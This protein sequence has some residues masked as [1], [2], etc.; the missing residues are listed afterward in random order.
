MADFQPAR[1]PDEELITAAFSSY[2]A[3]APKNFPHPPAAEVMAKA[4]T[5]RPRKRA[6]T[7]SLAALAFTGL[8][9]G[10]AA[11]AQTVASSG[12]M[13]DD[14]GDGSSSVASGEDGGSSSKDPSSSSKPDDDKT[15]D[16]DLHGLAITLP[17]WP[18]AAADCPAGTYTFSK[19]GVSKPDSKW[20]LASDG[21]VTALDDDGVSN[22]LIVEIDCDELSGVI[23]LER[24]DDEATA[25]DFVDTAEPGTAID[26]VSVDGNKVTVDT[27]PST[28]GQ[29]QET[30]V[31]D[32]DGFNE[33]PDEEPSDEPSSSSGTPSEEPSTSSPGSESTSGLLDPG[34]RVANGS[35]EPSVA[36][37]TP[38]DPPY[39][40][41]R[42]RG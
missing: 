12:E 15:E 21:T 8:I 40:D 20:S 27:G 24:D 35:A 18:E 32:G 26:V 33:A 17:D 37:R 31:Y 14:R 16:D 39:D 36:R 11:V 41:V 13:P 5:A 22:D 23:A 25:K 4:D 1:D 19:E 34:D 30:F 2:R 10:G 6:L 7:V 28:E 42:S 29:T 9:A 38:N 3:Q